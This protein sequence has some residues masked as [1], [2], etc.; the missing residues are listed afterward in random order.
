MK[1]SFEIKFEKVSDIARFIGRIDSRI[2][3]ALAHP[4]GE[5]CVRP[6]ES[7]GAIPNIAIR[8]GPKGRRGGG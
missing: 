5:N 8:D 2:L 6:T 3:A 7:P 4:F 1:I